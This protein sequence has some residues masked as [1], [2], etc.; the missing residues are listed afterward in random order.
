MQTIDGKPTLISWTPVA[1]NGPAGELS[2]ALVSARPVSRLALAPF[3]LQ[4]EALMLTAVTGTAT[5]LIFG[6]LYIL[7]V[8]PWRQAARAAK[9]LANGDLKRELYP[10]RL[11]EIGLAVRALERLRIS[12]RAARGMSTGHRFAD[13][14]EN[15]D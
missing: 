4:R 5:V 10:E 15:T 14:R 8:R 11:D 6:W 9:R 2:W 1:G 12:L 3:Q 7:V 13:P